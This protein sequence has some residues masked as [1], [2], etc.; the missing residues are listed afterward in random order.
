MKVVAFVPIRLNSKRVIG[1]NLKMLGSKPLLVYLLETLITVKNLDEIYVFCSSPEIKEYLP[2]GVKFLQRNESLD[3]DTTLGEE[4]YD[5]FIQT[6][7]ADVYMLAHV[8]SPFIKTT[9]IEK[10]IF[11]VKYKGY[12]SAFSAEKIKT[13]TWYQQ[14]PLN[15]SLKHIPRTQDL[16]P[17]FVE[18]SAFF[19]FKKEIWTNLHQRIGNKPYI[20]EVD[21]IEGVDIDIPQ[22]FDFAEKIL[23]L[24]NFQT[25]ENI[26]Q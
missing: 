19:I 5:A 9:T 23:P 13:F 20:A 26:Q 7:D 17:V 6:V 12:D 22:D 18:T 2:E 11:H 3:K 1:K 25:N 14:K 21:K 8:T 4:I 24:I 10:S 15:Y 16:E